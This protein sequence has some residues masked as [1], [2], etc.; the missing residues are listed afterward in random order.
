MLAGGRAL[1]LGLCSPNLTH[2][3]ISPHPL[4]VK[5]SGY[6]NTVTNIE[7]R[8]DQ[9]QIAAAIGRQLKLSVVSVVA[10][11]AGDHLIC[12]RSSAIL[13]FPRWVKVHDYVSEGTPYPLLS[14]C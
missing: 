6:K 11:D 12:A 7:V 10:E 9:L 4:Q 13:A 2:C 5:V 8:N 1:H 14:D 3:N